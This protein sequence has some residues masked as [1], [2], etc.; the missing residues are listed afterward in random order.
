MEFRRT[1]ARDDIVSIF[2]LVLLSLDQHLFDRLGADDE[3][4]PLT[5][6]KQFRKI[7][8]EHRLRYM[9][10]HLAKHENRDLYG[11]KWLKICK[12]LVSMAD[13]IESIAFDEKPSYSELRHKLKICRQI[14]VKI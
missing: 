12:Q 10:M 1:S 7:K 11:N 5:K 6:F 13:M 14:C 3:T 8:R 2:Y 4:D 9:V